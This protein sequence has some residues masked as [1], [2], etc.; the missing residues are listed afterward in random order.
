MNIFSKAA[1]GLNL[2]PA[3]RAFLKLLK[4]WFY[5]ALSTGIM[6]GAQ[7]LLNN[8]QINWMALLYIA[9][10]AFLLSI[11]GALDKYW[12]AQGD[13]PIAVL[14]D[15]IMQRVQGALPSLV[16]Q[17]VQQQLS[18]SIRASVGAQATQTPQAARYTPAINL[19][20]PP[21]ASA[22]TQVPQQAF[23]ASSPAIDF[24]TT[25]VSPAVNAKLS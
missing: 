3:Q 15:A 6:A 5:T 10:G 11:L 4:G 12:T 24:G 16:A 9:S 25:G 1:Q 17:H 20:Q 14:S 7:Y 22:T 19:A 2:S 23:P 13:T 18:T 21:V 8:Q